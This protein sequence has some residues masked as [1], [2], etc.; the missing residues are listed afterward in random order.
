MGTIASG[1][2][3]TLKIVASVT[4]PGATTDVASVSHSDQFDGNLVN[5]TASVKETPQQADL[6]VA[7]SVNAS[8]PNVGDKIT[9]TITV[10]N[11]GPN[12]ATNVSLSDVL[13]SGLSFFSSAGAGTYTSSS[14]VWNVGSVTSGSTQT[15]TIVAT[16][17]SAGATTD[18]ASVSHAD[19][20]DPN[21]VNNTASVTETPQQA[22]LAVTDTISATAPNVG[23]TVTYTVTVSNLGSNTAT[24]VS[25][26][27]VLPVG[28]SFLSSS[29]GGTYTSST[30]VWNVGSVTTGS[31]QTLTIVAK[32][33][34]PAATTDTASVS[35][36]DQY[37]PNL[38]NN[39]ASATEAP[40]QADLAV[41]DTISASTPNVG[42][43][44]TY[45]VTVANS[46]PNTATNVSLADVL[47][48]GLSFLSSGGTGTYTN[49][50]GVWNVGS[51]TSGSTQTL[52]I[53]AKVTSPAGSTD[54]A[55]VSHSDQY[56]PNLVNNTA[57]V[58][59]TPQQADLVVTDT[60]SAFIPNV[61]DTVTYTVTVKNSGPNLATNVSLSD[62][63]PAGLS[64]LSSGGSRYVHQL[65]RRVE[66][67]LGDERFDADVDDRG[68]GGEPG[69]SGGHGFGEPFRRVRSEPGEQ[70]GERVGN[71]ATGRL[72]GTGFHQL[73]DSER[74]RYG[75]L[76]G[77]R[78]QLRPEP[79]DERVTFGCA[80]VG[81][82]VPLV[83]RIG[84][85]YELDGRVERR[86][87]DERLDP[88][89]DDRGDKPGPQPRGHQ[90]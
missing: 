38:V 77:H 5:N 75:H 52:T 78:V 25:L 71:A 90:P 24:S 58:T 89:V 51:L 33:T 72:A 12:T 87:G 60:I 40:Q 13:P 15:L 73:V 28:L 29:G 37:D 80:S 31:T 14:G 46:G 39:T 18:T 49:S 85:V 76:H 22:D 36:S 63:L 48:A 17:V 83:W 35:H 62:V 45:T 4:S 54:T 88:D 57:S 3:Q 82:V 11:S 10:A 64:F 56:D 9:Y 65:E 55:S 61:G 26:Q 86:F 6:V 70:H 34:S 27:D 1:S 66:R 8:A 59:E 74:G 79:G 42:D 84:H 43:V 20:Y 47:P 41:T 2:T 19:Q 23:D 7:S 68:D 53:V 69:C 21:L 44:V 16:V 32:V 30:G 67:R 50:S 81:A